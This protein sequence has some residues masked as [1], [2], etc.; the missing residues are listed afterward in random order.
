MCEMEMVKAQLPFGARTAQKLM[1]IAK[2]PL[3]SNTTRGSY[4]PVSYT[5][6]YELTR[7]EE[8]ELKRSY[9]RTTCELSKFHSFS[10]NLS[11]TQNT[12][13]RVNSAS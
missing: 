10:A 2:H 5:T 6:L 13:S 1:A 7:W 12:T 8:P 4:F 9:V 3:I 11:K